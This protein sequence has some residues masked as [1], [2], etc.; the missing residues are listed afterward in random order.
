M[1]QKIRPLEWDGSH[2]ARG[3]VHS[4]RN[5]EVQLLYWLQGLNSCLCNQLSIFIFHSIFPNFKELV[6]KK[7]NNNLS[8]SQLNKSDTIFAKSRFLISGLIRIPQLSLIQE[9][10]SF[11]HWNISSRASFLTNDSDIFVLFCF[12]TILCLSRAFKANH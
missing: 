10:H 4:Q 5:P 7:N 8:S 3:L 6:L 11:R 1:A 9:K 12:F 2:L